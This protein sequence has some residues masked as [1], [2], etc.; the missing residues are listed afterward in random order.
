MPLVRTESLGYVSVE[1][2]KEDAP[3]VI[4]ATAPLLTGTRAVVY[5]EVPGADVPT[6]EGVEVVLG[7]RAGD[8][9]LVR[10]GLAEGDR[11]VVKGNFKIDS[12][13]QIEAKPSM[14][15]PEGGGAPAGHAPGGQGGAPA[16]GAPSHGGGR[17]D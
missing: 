5:R 1:P 2:T 10:S 14:M 15:A 8:F 3:L 7:P 4:P 9:Y 13:L 17:H 16:A 6:Y 12:A 11:V